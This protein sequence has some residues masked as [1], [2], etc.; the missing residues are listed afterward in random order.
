MFKRFAKD[1]NEF[2]KLSEVAIYG[3]LCFLGFGLHHRYNTNKISE[4]Q[5]EIEKIKNKSNQK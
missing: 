5:N 2:R 3:V 4:L 1:S